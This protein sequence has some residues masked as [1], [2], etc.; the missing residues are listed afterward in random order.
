MTQI[1]TL[2]GIDVSKKK[3]DWC[4]RGVAKAT[5]ENSVSG[6]RALAE[7]LK[8]H[9]VEMA[10]IEAS[11][12]YQ[13]TVENALRKAGFAVLTFNPKRVRD[14]AKAAGRRAKTDPI[15]ADT[16]AWFGEVFRQETVI[17]RDADREELA[18]LMSERQGFVDMKTQCENRGEHKRSALGEKL[19]RGTLER[20]ERCIAELDKA[21]A[22]KIAKTESLA[23]DAKLLLSVP[24]LGDTAV[25][26]LLAWLPELG[27]M[28]STKIAA[29]VGVAPFD[30]KSGERK[31]VQH[32]AGGRR[33]LRNLLFMPVMGAATRHNPI[34]KR[35]Y[36][37]LIAQGKEA[38][39]AL[40]ACMHKLLRILNIMLARRQSWNPPPLATGAVA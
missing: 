37:R 1:G 4:I 32:I 14:F 10:V 23:E 3:L 8:L 19:R 6:C 24:G 20:I 5:V 15:D 7:A 26:A 27:R 40:I 2:V 21:I 30:D 38:K 35:Y 9:N 34:L 22:A 33:D 39:V 29:L 17:A 36:Q 18:D 31:G 25:A 11:G 16:I 12:G 28:R 13:K